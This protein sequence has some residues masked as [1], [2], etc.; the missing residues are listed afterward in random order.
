MEKYS[1]AFAKALAERMRATPSPDPAMED[2]TKQGLVI[3]ILPAIQEMQD[4]GFTIEQ[5]AEIMR[6]GKFA[7]TTPTLKSY[8]QRIR[9][10]KPKTSKKPKT[11]KKPPAPLRLAA[12]PATPPTA[13]SEQA[14]ALASRGPQSSA[15][16]PSAS[17][18]D[19]KAEPKSTSS[20]FLNTD[21]KKL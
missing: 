12:V 21:R 2:L 15:V 8:L 3:D 17:G 7:I 18:E 1:K 9:G 16:A 11:A 19:D 6:E 14:P 4:R 13:T 5:V 10:K 20:E